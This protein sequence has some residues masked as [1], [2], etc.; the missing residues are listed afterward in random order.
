MRG[1]K[2]LE[3]LGLRRL[4][5]RE[6]GEGEGCCQHINNKHLGILEI[7]AFSNYLNIVTQS[8]GS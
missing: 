1:V 5:C 6:N 8:C 7:V 2:K 4:A 3:M